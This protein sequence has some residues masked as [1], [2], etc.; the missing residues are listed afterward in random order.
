VPA[1]VVIRNFPC[2]GRRT[3]RNETLFTLVRIVLVGGSEGG[4]SVRV[5][6][7]LKALRDDGCFLALSASEVE[8]ER[9]EEPAGKVDGVGLQRR[10]SERNNADAVSRGHVINTTC[11][12]EEDAALQTHAKRDAPALQSGSAYCWP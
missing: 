11:C 5:A 1:S 4:G 9:I 10:P 6:V 2:C 12:T 7:H 3:K 8:V